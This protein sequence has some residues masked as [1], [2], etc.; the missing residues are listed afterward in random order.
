MPKIRAKYYQVGRIV[1]TMNKNVNTRQIMLEDLWRIFVQRWVW[2]V[3]IAAVITVGLFAL[4][5]VTFVPQYKST[6]TLYLLRQE[7]ASENQPTSLVSD[8]SIGLNVVT[9]CNHLIK[10]HSVVGET[11]S[12]L[13]L[14]TTYEDLVRS[15]STFSP[16]ESRVMEV[17]VVADT[18]KNAKSIVDKLCEIG[19]ER[20]SD[21][22]SFNQ[23]RVFEPGTLEEKP[24]NSKGLAT[25][26]C[27]G[28]IAAI[29]VYCFF[30][31]I[32]L[33][34][35]KLYTDE[36]IERYLGLSVL[37]EIPSVSDTKKK[38]GY[39]RYGYGKSAG[40]KGEK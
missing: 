27:Y 40:E 3:A 30:L 31:M 34:D 12:S 23:V 11:I 2:V 35:D 17:S 33:L 10:S 6:A 1:E 5:K 9:D 25:F 13:G 14:D 21:A 4:E 39:Y 29:L 22:M 19:Q 36:E 20:I 37:G 24:C 38:K 16:E 8:F 26:I 18:P 7:S 28:L 32:F 15:I